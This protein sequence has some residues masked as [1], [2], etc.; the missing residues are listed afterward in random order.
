MIPE[1]DYGSLKDRVAAARAIGLPDRM[2][3]EIQIIDGFP[4]WRPPKEPV[5]KLVRPEIS[6]I[7]REPPWPNHG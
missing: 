3:N 5:V 2:A 7:R 4:E 1:I 6:P